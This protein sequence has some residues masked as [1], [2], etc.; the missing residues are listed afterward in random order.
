M[1]RQA[2]AFNLV[3]VLCDPTDEVLI[4]VPY[5]VSY[6]EMVF[7]AEAVPIFVPTRRENGFK[8]TAEELLKKITPKTKLLFLNTPCN[9]T[10]S[11][12]SKEELEKLATV[13]IEKKIFCISDEIYEKCLYDGAKH[14]SI[15]AFGDAIYQ[16]TITVNGLSKSFAMTGWRIGYFGAPEWISQ[17]VGNFQSHSTS[18]PASISQK[19]ALAALKA[20]PGDI[21]KLLQPLAKRRQLMMEGLNGIAT[22]S[23][24]I[25]SGAFYIF[26]D[27]QKTRMDSVAFAKRLLEETGVVCVPGE[28]FGDKYAIRLSFATSESE[29]QEGIKRMKE[30]LK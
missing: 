15:A 24:L 18:N 13:L 23:F 22:L 4:P 30:F 3:Q 25:P 16:Q 21:Q 28:A 19:A 26:C 11:V 20:S 8:I 7:L 10:G 12:Y 2:R 1:R 27:I 29:I 9:P 14:Y 6:P 17:A 5:W